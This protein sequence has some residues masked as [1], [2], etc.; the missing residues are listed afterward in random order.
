MFL[1]DRQHLVNGS[2]NCIWVM[3][4]HDVT[5][6]FFVALTYQSQRGNMAVD[7]HVTLQ[8]SKKQ[9]NAWRISFGYCLM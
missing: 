1:Y 8:K 3:I 6:F 5:G 4:L 7:T 2:E 9:E